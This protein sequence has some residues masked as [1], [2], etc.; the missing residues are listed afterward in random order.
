M[1]TSIAIGWERFFGPDSYPF[2][3]DHVEARDNTDAQVE[4]LTTLIPKPP[5]LVVDLG[6]GNGRH[7][8]RLA[9]LGFTV[10]AIDR[11]PVP[12]EQHTT[13]VADVGRLPLKPESID[14]CLSLYTSAGYRVGTLLKQ[15]REWHRVSRP[16]GIL[17]IDFANQNRRLHRAS[18]RFA[19]GAGKMWSFRVLGRRYQINLATRHSQRT[20][21]AFSYPELSAMHMHALLHRARWQVVDIVGDYDGSKHQP[22]SRRMIFKAQR[23]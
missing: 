19:G 4:L 2:T 22:S 5:C 10:L 20:L 12:G 8:R 15:L 11:F 21:Y 13:V 1:R 6:S 16:D 14:V 18:D 23:C 17:I 7:A 9:A 3:L